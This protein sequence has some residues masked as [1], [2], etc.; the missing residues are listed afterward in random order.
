MVGTP[1][2]FSGPVIIS[3][4]LFSSSLF[5]GMVFALYAIYG[6]KVDSPSTSLLFGV[7]GFAFFF[8]ARDVV[9]CTS[10]SNRVAGVTIWPSRPETYESILGLQPQPLQMKT[11]V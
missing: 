10:E 7:E 9:M 5:V 6:R 2:F 8:F 1:R 4:F 11:V 3:S